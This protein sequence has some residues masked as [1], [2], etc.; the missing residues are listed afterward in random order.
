MVRL[1]DTVNKATGLNCKAADGQADITIGENTSLAPEGY[2][3]EITEQGVRIEAS[4]SDGVYYAMQSLMRLLPA[5]VIL[6]KP[7]DEDAVYALPVAR[8]E[9][10]PRFAYRGFMLDVSRHFFTIEQV[11]LSL[12]HI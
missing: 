12:I 9:D 11:K 2:V 3:M 1:I 6:G 7:G 8:I 5:N 10:E 4:T